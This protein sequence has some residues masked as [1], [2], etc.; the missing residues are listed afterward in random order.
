MASGKGAKKLALPRSLHRRDAYELTAAN[1]KGCGAQTSLALTI[2]DAHSIGNKNRAGLVRLQYIDW[3]IVGSSASDHKFGELLRRRMLGGSGV[4]D[5]PAAQDGHVIGHREGFAQ[6]VRD[7]HRGLTCRHIR[8]QPVEQIFHF[9]WREDGGRLV[10]NE[11]RRIAS[12]R[13][14]DFDPLLRAHGQRLHASHR[15]E[16]EARAFGDH[17]HAGSHRARVETPVATKRDVLLYGHGGNQ[18]EM[19]VHHSDSCRNRGERRV[20]PHLAA[21]N[22]NCSGIGTDQAVRHVHE[23]CLS[24]AVLPQ[25]CVHGTRTH[26]DRDIVKSGEGAVVL[27]DMRDFEGRR[28]HQPFVTA[29]S[30]RG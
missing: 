26:D 21:G 7:E 27:A 1:G 23:R 16:R 11:Q 20:E 14:G 9:G 13:F 24:C 3:P 15:I 22:A 4:Y 18:R 28:R 2:I 10:E 8:T 19:L 6:F 25:Y 29:P 5:T 30:A 12:Q 17:F